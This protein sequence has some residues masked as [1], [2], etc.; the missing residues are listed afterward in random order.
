MKITC[1]TTLIL[2]FQVINPARA[3][4]PLKDFKEG[5]AIGAGDKLWQWRGDLNG[6]G[7]NDLLLCLKSDAEESIKNTDPPSWVFYLGG[8]AGGDYSARPQMK[9]SNGDVGGALLEIDP[10]R[11]F[12]GQIAELGRRGMV[13]IRYRNPREGPSM[14]IIYAYT[15]EGDYLRKTEL[16]RFSIAAT[17]HALFTQYLADD[18]RTVITPVELAP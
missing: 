11:C 13:T 1:I 9:E 5:L 7:K 10:G 8:A 17:P 6:D 12:V 4:D 3:L 15:M 18:K 14:G 2:A 16:A